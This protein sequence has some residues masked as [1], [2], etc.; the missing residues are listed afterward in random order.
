MALSTMTVKFAGGFHAS[1]T[2]ADDFVCLNIT[3]CPGWGAATKISWQN[4]PTS[5]FATRT[6]AA[7]AASSSTSRMWPK[8]T[9]RTSSPKPRQS[10]RSCSGTTTT[11]RDDRDSSPASASCRSVP[12]L[13]QL[14]LGSIKRPTRLTGR[15]THPLLLAVSRRTGANCFRDCRPSLWR[16][17]LARA[18]RQ[19]EAWN[20][21]GNL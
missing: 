17:S 18:Q 19:W 20:G 12:V 6:R 13:K 14:P 8:S 11:T 21:Y 15:S 7:P 4:L 10:A 1:F 3:R 16:V 9:A 5:R 2:N